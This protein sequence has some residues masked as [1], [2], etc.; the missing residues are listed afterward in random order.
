[1]GMEILGLLKGIFGGDSILM[2]ILKL[3][4][5]LGSIIAVFFFLRWVDKQQK[6]M[7]HDVTQKDR[8]KEQSEIGEENKQIFDDAKKSEDSI[9]DM[10]KKGGGRQ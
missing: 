2:T 1:M 4:S 9:E 7:A 5:G 3:V 6:S 8:A 10:I